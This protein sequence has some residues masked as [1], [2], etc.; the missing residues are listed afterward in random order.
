MKQILI[1]CAA[2]AFAFAAVSC[3][4]KP[5]I[6]AG[7]WSEERA[8]AWYAAQE[9]PV[10]FNYVAATAINQFEM[11][12]PETF[13]P[14][15]I[16][17]EM[18]L[19]EGLGF[20]TVRIFLHDMVWEADPEGFKKRI[21]RFL[22][23]CG[24]HGMKTIVTFFTNGG[25]FENPRLGKQPDAVQGV[26]N[27]QWIQ[28]PGAR[29]V[30]DPEAWPRLERYVKD[31]LTTFRDDDRILLW[32]LY[33]EPE[34]GKQGARSL[35][36]L[37]EVFRW[38]REVAPSQPL[39]SPVWICPGLH[40]LRS[41]FPIVSFLG[42]NCDVMT[43][44]CYY[45]PE[46][47]KTFI[48]LMKQFGRPVICQEYMGRPNSTFEQIM[49]ILKSESV[50]AIS[51]GLTAGKCNFHLQWSSKAGDPEPEV[52][53][54]DIYRTDGTPYSQQEVDFIRSM[55]ADKNMNNQ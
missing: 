24:R 8:N 48:G 46:E 10:G 51:W 33:N 13:D 25:R 39:S 23:I 31:I 37:R 28:S 52:W 55:T 50:G 41:N 29:A 30:N 54:H 45:G 40:G 53:F 19:A 18:D 35:P 2:L 34:S 21:G 3:S 6:P 38:G 16:E 4:G 20:N 36:L 1:H 26:H 7:R 49:P 9:W 14:Q 15:T 47:M 11:W 5:R 43:F 42:E 32:C 17:H 12:Q 44:H 27:S 22:D